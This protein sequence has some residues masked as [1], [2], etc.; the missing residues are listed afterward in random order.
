MD[1]KPIDRNKNPDKFFSEQEKKNIV[2]AITSAEKETS[3][4]IR[5]HLE[6]SAKMEPM[7]RAIQVFNKIGMNK[8]AQRNGV[9]LYLA[10]GDHQFAIIGDKGINELVPDNYWDDIA[11]ELGNYFKNREFC[12]GVCQGIVRIGE[13]LKEF[14]P[15]QTDDENELSDDI[16]ISDK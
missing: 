12:E 3:G 15:Y 9:L 4:E 16:S 7:K 10:T 13:K 8:T 11:L 6:R 5:L 1:K 2:L 14:F